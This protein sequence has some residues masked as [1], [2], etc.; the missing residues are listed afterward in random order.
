MKKL[1]LL[2]LILTICSCAQPAPETPKPGAKRLPHI[3]ACYGTITEDST[4]NPLTGEKNYNIPLSLNILDRC[5][6]FRLVFA[7][8]DCIMIQTLNLY[9]DCT[10]EFKV[11]SPICHVPDINSNVQNEDFSDLIPE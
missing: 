10:N 1:L 9:I 6:N 2:T 3:G 5:P 7:Y 8:E 4:C 11:L